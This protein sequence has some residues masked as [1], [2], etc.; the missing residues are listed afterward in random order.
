MAKEPKLSLEELLEQAIVKEE[1]KPYEVPENW[2][3]V[4]L[5]AV[6]S[7]IGGGTPSKEV[8]EF[9]N[10]SILWASV[11]DIKNT[12]LTQ[13]E[14]R[15]TELGFKNSATSLAEPGDVILV[16]RISPGK[17][18]IASVNVAIN[19]DLKIVRKKVPINAVFLWGYF[20]LM[21]SKIENMASG[22]T[23]MGIT[24]EKVYSLP[25][26]LPP[27]PEQQRI[28][29]L[30]E[31]LFEKL[32]R[33]KELAQNALDSFENRKTAILHKAFTGEL[34]RKWREENEVDLDS[35]EDSR[36][37]NIAEIISGTNFK[38]EDFSQKNVV[39]C[40][41]ITNVGVGYFD[42]ANVDYL[43]SEFLVD[44]QKQIVKCNDVLI[45][46]T[47]PF[48][49]AGLKTC[50][51][52]KEKESLLNQRV[53]L[54]RGENGQY[55]YHY[56]RTSKVL[57]YIKEKS[58]TT[59]QPNLS[60]KDL[61]KLQIPCPTIAEQKEIIRILDKLLENEQKAKELCDI[62]DKI[63][64]MKKSILARAF[65]GELS[66]NNPAEESA[67]ELLKEVLMEKM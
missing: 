2:V 24:V 55:I 53:A 8:T 33:A 17:S 10:G 22:T 3:W 64:H 21:I 48:I 50:I 19:Q 34:T 4:R 51:Y 23:V 12:Y 40:V 66:T 42:D 59:N 15:I 14:D 6:I 47:R 26:S 30:I 28:V 38:S 18:S 25:F 7:L 41:K 63:D 65:R 11:K 39:S 27:L 44:F 1:D 58:K 20:T 56:L 61:E 31:S 57:E 45:A 35:W 67:L 37:K 46:L 60:I 29:A 54:I 9:W 43:P 36:L 49:N 16:T 5:G 32:D 52:R 62:I 13:T